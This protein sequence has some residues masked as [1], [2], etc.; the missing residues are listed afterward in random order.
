[1]KIIKPKLATV[2]FTATSL[3]KLSVALLFSSLLAVSAS[4]DII[5]DFYGNHAI[6]GKAK[7]E[8]YLKDDYQFGSEITAKNLSKLTFTSSAHKFT[9]YP[10]EILSIYAALH[11]NGKIA[12]NA[13]NFQFYI[14]AK[15]NKFF[16]TRKDGTWRSKSDKNDGNLGQWI[17]RSK[18]FKRICLN[19]DNFHKAAARGDRS[20]ISQCLKSGVPVN[21]KEGNGWTALHSAVNKGQI[22]TVRLLLKHGAKKTIK[23]KFGR[24][25]RDYAVRGKK[26]NMISV[27]D[28]GH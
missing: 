7:A 8:L 26:Y 20:Y 2:I 12:N 9:I 16:G 15:N 28:T 27:L 17:L 23:D 1:M 10:K 3:S 24:T 5:F 25:A 13:G 6:H 21:T 11:L 4:A 14:D 18:G 19:H 22:N